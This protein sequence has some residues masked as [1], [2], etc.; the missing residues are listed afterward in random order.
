MF[1]KGQSGNPSGVTKA[2]ALGDQSL[3]NL[4]GP[5]EN[6]LQSIET[7]RLVEEWQSQAH[8]TIDLEQDC[9]N[10]AQ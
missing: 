1:V 5:Q 10:S 4:V 2:L 9:R 7:I 8:L 3:T 6:N